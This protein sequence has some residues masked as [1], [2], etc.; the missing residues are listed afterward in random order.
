MKKKTKQ[1]LRWLLFSAIWLIYDPSK[2]PEFREVSGENVFENFSK[3]MKEAEEIG[4]V[5]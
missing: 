4:Y 5:K 1:L 3:I 2:A